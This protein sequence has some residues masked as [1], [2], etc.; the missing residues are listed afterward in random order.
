MEQGETV[1]TDD[2]GEID[3]R[4]YYTLAYAVKRD[5]DIEPATAQFD[6]SETEESEGEA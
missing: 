5:L 3:E 4:D 2:P 1:I 6:A